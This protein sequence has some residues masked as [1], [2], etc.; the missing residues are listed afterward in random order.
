[1]AVQRFLDG[2]RNFKNTY[3]D[4]EDSLFSSL[5]KGQHPRVMVVSCCD[6]RVDPA[7]M[8]GCHPGD[9][10]VVR[11]IAA[12]VP[13]NGRAAC[14]DSTIAALSYGVLHLK[15]TDL[16]V[17]GHSHCGG[18]AALTQE[19]CT[20]FPGY[21]SG[22]LSHARPVLELAE[23][24]FP[25]LEGD[26]LHAMREHLSV[27]LSTDALLTYPWIRERVEEGKLRLHP[28]FFDLEAGDLLCYSREHEAF[29]RLSHLRPQ[30]FDGADDVQSLFTFDKP[31]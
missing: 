12:L 28:W 15:V 19:S 1:M 22:W 26:E 23:Q 18:I 13:E 4:G 9:I 8:L 7:L 3:H 16:I 20:S 11:N 6:S 5:R 29:E 10:F 24:R 27:L 14:G 21:L 2:F 17:L 31:E 30:L 25:E